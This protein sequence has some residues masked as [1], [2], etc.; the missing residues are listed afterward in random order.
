[1]QTEVMLPGE[2]QVCSKQLRLR[3]VVCHRGSTLH[4][5]HYVTHVRQDRRW[6]TYDDDQVKFTYHMPVAIAR[7]GRLVLYEN[8]DHA[9]LPS[10]KSASSDAKH[11]GSSPAQTAGPAGVSQ[12]GETSA[13]GST[14]RQGRSAAGTSLNAAVACGRA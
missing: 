1:M 6:I 4:S 12:R 8:V 10:H 3:A 9:G 7:T 14:D 5:G 13:A 2:M 11:S